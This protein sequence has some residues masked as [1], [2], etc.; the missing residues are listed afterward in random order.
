[1]K[2]E[3]FLKYNVDCPVCNTKLC[4]RAEWI[5]YKIFEA[6][7][8]K[9]KKNYLEYYFKSRGENE[10][11]IL[12]I[13]NSQISINF[14][15]SSLKR[16]LLKNQ[17]YFY[18]SCQNRYSPSSSCY[19]RS[20]PLLQFESS[21]DKTWYLDVVLD[22]SKEII[23]RN[24]TITIIEKFEE[25]YKVHNVDVNNEENKTTFE[26]YTEDEGSIAEYI[27]IELPYFNISNLDLSLD[28]R[29]NLIKRF[30][31]WIMLS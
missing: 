27:F 31:S 15:P 4:L 22:T 20:T 19:Y 14:I 13:D 29:S 24:E 1:M 17:V 2:L 7:H 28:N 5:G 11:M 23:N 10:A 8:L 9:N 3:Q 16:K 21:P 25:N 12:I 30:K 26:S 6:V 18:F